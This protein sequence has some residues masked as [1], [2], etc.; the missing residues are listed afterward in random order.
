MEKMKRYAI[1]YAPEAGAFADAAAAWLG[2]DLQAGKPVPQPHYDLQRPL[3]DITA[4]PR[5]YGF[6]AT[7]K[8]PFRLAE[9]VVFADLAKAVAS[10]AAGLRAVALPN[11]QLVNLEGFLALIPEGD[12]TDLQ[13]L[14]AE[15]V[16]A[17]DPCRAALTH[18]ETARRRPESLS[19]RQRDLLAL[20][21][22]PYV[23]EEFQFHLTLSGALAQTEFPVVSAAAQAHFDGVLPQP[24]RVACL[25]LCGEDAEGRFHL[26]RRYDLSA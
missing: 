23:M 20:Y 17:I 6:H 19:E 22:Y 1:Y 15:V 3:R 13:G 21:G 8:P 14:A 11:L 9:G 16:R 7:I 2:W 24:F 26:L 10:L 4:G 5:K 25:C 12:C 18:A